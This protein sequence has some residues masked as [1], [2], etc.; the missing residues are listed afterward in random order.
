[1]PPNIVQRKGQPKDFKSQPWILFDTIVARS[2]LWGD[3]VN[4]IAV[5]TNLPAISGGGEMIFFNAP[6][7][8]N[9]TTPWYSNLDQQS[10]LSFGLE[11][12]QVYLQ[13]MFP[14]F[15]PNQNIGYDLEANAGVPGTIKLMEA[16]LNFG[17]LEMDLGQENQMRWPLS[18]FGAGGGLNVNAGVVTTV[19]QNGQVQ[20]NNV[21]RLPEPIEMPRTQNFAAKIRLAPEVQALIGTPAAPGVGQPLSNYQYGIANPNNVP[22]IASLP[23]EPFSVQLGLIGRRIKKTQYGQIPAPQQA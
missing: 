10:T 4:G 1:M 19:G 7:R 8:N 14:A 18:R 15:T 21:L 16:I 13:F 22:T 6:G 17:V 20:T 3:T 12:W 5:G 2:F 23:Q 9:S 11:V